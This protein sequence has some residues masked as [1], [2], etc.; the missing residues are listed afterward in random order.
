[1]SAVVYVTRVFIRLT[2]FMRGMCAVRTMLADWRGSVC[3]V[4]GVFVRWWFGM[5]IV[6]HLGMVMMLVFGVRV[7]HLALTYLKH[8]Q[9]ALESALYTYLVRLT[10]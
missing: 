2:H 7:C 3:H 6:F 10:A 8:L 5:S 9:C 1:M 4:V